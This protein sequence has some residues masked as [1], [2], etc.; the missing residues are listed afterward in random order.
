MFSCCS[1]VSIIVYLIDVLNY[2][3]DKGNHEYTLKMI[4]GKNVITIIRLYRD[5][6]SLNSFNTVG[7]VY[8]DKS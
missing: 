3:T 6:S 7:T 2:I 5:G 8:N 1:K 4:L